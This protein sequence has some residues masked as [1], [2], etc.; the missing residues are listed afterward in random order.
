MKTI[1]TIV[2]VAFCS[3]VITLWAQPAKQNP[4]PFNQSMSV[5]TQTHIQDTLFNKHSLPLYYIALPDT[6]GNTTKSLSVKAG[7][8]FYWK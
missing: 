2:L 6:T 7:G 8:G 5:Y 3:V 1:A 4:A